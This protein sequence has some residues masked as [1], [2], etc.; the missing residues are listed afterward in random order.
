[1]KEYQ[2][3]QKESMQQQIE[4]F[5]PNS[6]E[7]TYPGNRLSLPSEQRFQESI[8]PA[9]PRDIEVLELIETNF[10]KGLLLLKD[11]VKDEQTG[12]I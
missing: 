1:M 12:A 2:Q 11:L 5:D 4:S 3:G 10:E 7:G 9:Q 6:E 8:E